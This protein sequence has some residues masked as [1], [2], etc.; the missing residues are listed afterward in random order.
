MRPA[1]IFWHF[2]FNDPTRLWWWGLPAYTDGPKLELE[3]AAT[4]PSRV[5]DASVGDAHCLLLTLDGLYAYGEN[6]WNE[7]QPLPNT[8]LRVARFEKVHFELNVASV[9]CGRQ[10]SFAVTR[11]GHLYSWGSGAHGELA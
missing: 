10:N 4:A 1:I 2:V 5:V 9:H 3:L 6:V 7:T 11:N 8:D